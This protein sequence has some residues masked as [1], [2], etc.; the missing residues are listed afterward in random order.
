MSKIGR[1]AGKV[2]SAVD[3]ALH[4]EKKAAEER[5]KERRVIDIAERALAELPPE[6]RE[7]AI[8]YLVD[9]FLKE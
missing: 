6:G 5:L 8:R 9:L 7:R 2:G 1:L 3:D 4:P